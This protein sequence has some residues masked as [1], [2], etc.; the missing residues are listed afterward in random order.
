VDLTGLRTILDPVDRRLG[1]GLDR[2]VCRYHRRRLR[3]LGWAHALD[4]RAPEVG[5]RGYPAR[6]G[7]SVRVLV[8]GEEAM[9]AMVAAIWHPVAAEQ[10]RLERSGAPRTHRLA[11][12]PNVSRRT[13]RLQGPLRGLLVDG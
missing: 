10:S 11:L 8:D 2:L 12:L 1:D 13:E 7:N 9:A 4:A 5:G 6:D 3:R